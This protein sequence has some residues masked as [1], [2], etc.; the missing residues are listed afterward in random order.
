MNAGLI[1]I[2]LAAII[3]GSAALFGELHASPFWI[4]GARGLFAAIT[5]FFYAFTVGGLNLTSAKNH[6]KPLVITG[7][8]LSY[9]W[10]SFFASVQMADIAIATLTF[11]TFPLFTILLQSIRAKSWPNLIEIA[12]GAVIVIAVGM[13]VDVKAEGA[14][15]FGT[16]IGLTSA[17]AFAFFGVFAKSLTLY[18]RPI[19]ISFVQNIVVVVSML[20]FLGFMGPAPER[21]SDWMWLVVL[22]VVT[23]ALMHQLYLFA[24][25]RLSA[26]TCSGFIALEPVYAIAFAAILF[27]QPI[28]LWVVV[29]GLMI[30][31]ASL[32]L[33]FTDRQ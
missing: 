8:L 3:F 4:V 13:L 26:K 24:L 20:P 10:V 23:T 32:A 27:G 19:T 9:H 31:G 1:A 14:K 15:L 12:A 11:A 18:M 2:N 28:T 30:I 5:L 6:L 7:V 17:L 29:S 33:L 21:G 25:S 16:V 22:G